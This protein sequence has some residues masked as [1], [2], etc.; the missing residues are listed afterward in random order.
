MLRRAQFSAITCIILVGC[1]LMVTQWG[2][3]NECTY[4]SDFVYP[5]SCFRQ[6]STAVSASLECPN[7]AK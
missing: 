1:D 5:F 6:F 7:T 2:L 3:V 4:V